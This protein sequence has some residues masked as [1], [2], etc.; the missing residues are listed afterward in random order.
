MR[1]ILLLLP[2][3]IGAATPAFAEDT[4]PFRHLPESAPPALQYLQRSGVKLTFLGEQGGLQGYLG[5]SAT[6]KVQTFYLTP[7][8]NHVVAGVLFRRGGINV[9]GVQIEDM[10]S[11]FESARKSME[12]AEEE[13][14]NVEITDELPPPEVPRLPDA[15]AAGFSAV[16][17][18]SIADGGQ[19]AAGNAE[20]WIS[21]LDRDKFLEDVQNVA[22]F[23]VGVDTAPVIYMVADPQC[24]Y[25]HAAWGQLRP[26][27]T[28]REVT[29]RIILIDAL[30]GSR[31]KAISLLSRD[32]PGRAWF[33][34]EGSLNG[35]AI[36]PPP[37]SD[38]EEYRE[39]TRYLNINRDFA[40]TNG[41]D[42]TPY[43]IYEGDDGLLRSSRG[44]PNDLD[45][46]LAALP[47]TKE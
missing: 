31:E 22:W 5:E 12:N 35:M 3:L 16:S 30:T 6:G 13:V 33:A 46:F 39:A 43:L 36:A 8:G 24:P 21:H 28:A 40:A 25:C 11:R 34:G 14:G 4:N 37:A 26:K 32:E 27:V 1:K 44:L 29:L 38:T 10:K 20:A 19:E 18:L 45:A 23:S 7:D 2:I 41:F 17:G 42:A 9:T 47:E 15:S